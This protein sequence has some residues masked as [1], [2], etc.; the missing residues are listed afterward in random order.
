MTGLYLQLNNSVVVP[1]FTLYTAQ[2]LYQLLY[3]I[4]VYDVFVPG[5]SGLSQERVKGDLTYMPFRTYSVLLPHSLVDYCTSTTY[6]DYPF[7]TVPG[8][9]YHSE[10]YEYVRTLGTWY[11]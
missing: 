5:K 8:Y 3:C 9:S 4:R 2:G 1:L 6:V 11:P 10:S 7:P